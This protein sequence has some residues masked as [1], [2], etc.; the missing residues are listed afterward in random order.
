MTI[1]QRVDTALKTAVK[2]NDNTRREAS[3]SEVVKIA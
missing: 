2:A 1:E 3:S